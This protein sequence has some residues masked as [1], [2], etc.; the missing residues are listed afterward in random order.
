M[1]RDEVVAEPRAALPEPGPGAAGKKLLELMRRLPKHKR[2]KTDVSR[3][4][5]KHLQVAL[6]F[7][8][9]TI[10]YKCRLL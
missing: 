4:V 2:R 9:L 5:K 6:R 8:F 1:V 10:F 3:H 7:D